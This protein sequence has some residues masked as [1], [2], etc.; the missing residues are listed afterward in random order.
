[1]R[2]LVTYATA[3]ALLLSF[4]LPAAGDDH[5][6]P[7]TRLRSAGVHQK[8]N[9]GTYCWTRGNMGVCADAF[10][11]DWPRAR[12]HPGDRPAR[13]K[14]GR[15]FRPFQVHLRGYRHLDENRQPKGDGFKLA[16]RVTKRKVD[17][18]LRYFIRFRVPD[19]SGH[20]Y[21]GL[22]THLADETG[23]RGDVFYDFHLKIE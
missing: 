9:L 13:I 5:R 22:W 20:L 12:R 2:R 3:S 18:R 14:V 7:K 21:L 15:G 4:P 8:G 6:P 11:H 17:G 10:G 23:E 16:T 19:K 1:M